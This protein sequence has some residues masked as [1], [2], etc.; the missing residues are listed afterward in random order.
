M[1]YYEKKLSEKV[2]YR[3]NVEKE[4]QQIEIGIQKWKRRLTKG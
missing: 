1:K 3:V 4:G 2:K